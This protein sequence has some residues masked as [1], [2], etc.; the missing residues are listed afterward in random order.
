MLRRQLGGKAR[1]DPVAA[2]YPSPLPYPFSV[3]APLVFSSRHPSSSEPLEHQLL[4]S[5]TRR[6]L[7]RRLA[8]RLSWKWRAVL[9]LPALA[10]AAGLP[11]LAFMMVYYT[12]S[13]PHPLAM[14]GKERAPVIRILARDGS[15]LA[16]R[17]A[18][19]DYMP[20]DLLPGHVT[21]AVVAIEDRRFFNHSGLDPAGF[22]RAVFA[23]LRA[24]RLAQGGSTLT[25]QLAKNLFLT[26]ER[27]FSR[28][29]EE[30]ALALW[31]ELRLT[32]GE[33]LEL[34]LNR[35]YFGA[36]AYGIEAASQRYFDKS[37]RALS[38]AEAAILAGLLKAPSKYSPLTSPDMAR[39]RGRVVVSKM[40][41]T[42]VISPEQEQ[43]SQ[44]EHVKFSDARS[45]T[46]ASG[47]DYPIDFV[48]ER[49]P[50]LIG[51]GHAEIVVETTIDAALQKRAGDIVAQALARQG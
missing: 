41:E 15:V 51:G 7:V 2:P 40:A 43:R 17:G 20:L 27:T 30:F 10:A 18:A 13:F 14:R 4:Q 26:S 21:G 46:A 22:A 9:A 44:A 5:S 29:L 34:Y 38:V 50:P 45:Q 35:V 24:G 42:G 47:L 3:L 36:G 49:L 6:G 25:Q 33:I 16:E 23:N 37:A 32:K 28:K 11:A 8:Q 19:H 31:L 12:V 39:A 1:S 48:L